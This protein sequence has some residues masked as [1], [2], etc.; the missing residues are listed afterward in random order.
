[1]DKIRLPKQELQYETKA[2]KHGQKL[3]TTRQPKQ[4]PLYKSKLAK[5]FTDNGKM[6]T[7]KTITII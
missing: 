1:M 3:Y 7:K 5:I 4:T 6:K 2:P